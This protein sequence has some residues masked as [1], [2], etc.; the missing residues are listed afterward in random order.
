MTTTDSPSLS[1]P[2]PE[3]GVVPPEM[4][5]WVIRS[6]RFGPPLESFRRESMKTPEPGP[7]EVL[8]LV[9]AAGVNY[10][11]IWA[12]LGKPVSVLDV[13]K[14]PFHIAGSDASGVVWKLGTGVTRWK[15]GDEVVL[16][17]NVTCGQCGACNGFD[18]MACEEQKIWGYETP[19]GSFAQFTL[20][21]AQQLLKKPKELTWEVASSYGLV[22]FTAYR[23]LVDRARVRPGENVLI[24]G[25][26]GGL[27]IFAVQI[28]KLLGATAIGIVSSKERGALATS[29]G[30]DH[31]IYRNDYPGLAYHPNETPEQGKARSEATKKLGKRFWELI[32]E[33]KGPDVVFE[34]VGQETFPTSVFLTNRMGR[35]VICGATTGF[36]LSFDVRHLWMR[37]KSIVWSHFAN[38]E[39][40]QRA[41]ELVHQGKINPVLTETFEYARIPEAHDVMHRNKHMGTIACLVCAPRMGLLNLADARTTP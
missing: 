28:T 22:Y 26:S 36:Q 37:Q 10:N 39:E 19:Y 35:I 29:V 34:H 31:L 33:R 30:C 3:L 4:D 7:G 15:V 23:M 8:V 11:G 1:P 16:H 21:Q 41:N 38:A 6:E 27:G 20:V 18:P 14:Q 5:A 13:H 2:I 9:M 32:G 40:C 25:A 12:G 17:C 24:W